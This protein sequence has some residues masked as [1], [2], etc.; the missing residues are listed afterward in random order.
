MK[1][2]EFREFCVYNSAAFK[3]SSE[4]T[5]GSLGAEID[6]Y[7]E[8]PLDESSDEEINKA[9]SFEKYIEEGVVTIAEP[10]LG[11]PTEAIPLRS[12]PAIGESSGIP[13]TS[14][15]TNILTKNPASRV[16]EKSMREM[17]L[18]Y[19]FPSTIEVR[20]VSS[21]ER[22]DYK[23]PGWIGF[24]ERPFVDGFRFPIPK[25]V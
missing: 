10:P 6:K 14:E 7:F 18:K 23:I 25:L 1:G 24:Y 11:V 15:P 22:I 5:L 13:S 20:L 17:K 9:W 21:T 16:T 19:K 8:Q 3:M 2:K 12:F 4:E